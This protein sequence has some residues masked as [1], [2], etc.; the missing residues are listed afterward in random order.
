MATRIVDGKPAIETAVAAILAGLAEQELDTFSSATA[1]EIT[2]QGLKAATM[3]WEMLESL[4]AGDGTTKIALTSI[5]DT[6]LA[7]VTDANE[8]AAWQLAQGHIL[9]AIFDNAFGKLS[10]YGVTPATL[11]ILSSVLTNAE[12]ALGAGGQFSI[13]A[14]AKDLETLLAAA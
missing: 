5:I 12:A 10:D 2:A 1:A 9:V 13:D 7:C 3:H 14:F 11:T 6:V 4:P 8:K